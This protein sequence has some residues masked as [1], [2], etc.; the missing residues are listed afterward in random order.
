SRSALQKKEGRVATPRE[1]LPATAPQHAS[2]PAVRSKQR[3][4]PVRH[5]PP[6]G[7][8]QRQEVLR[9]LGIVLKGR[10]VGVC[11]ADSRGHVR[12]VAANRPEDLG[13]S[14]VDDV[15]ATLRGL[16][17]VREADRTRNLWVAG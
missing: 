7:P 16:G 10:G 9:R 8:E 1:A 12:L 3:G 11:E 5:T 17:E 6:S 15:K 13:P 4:E 2:E 14:V